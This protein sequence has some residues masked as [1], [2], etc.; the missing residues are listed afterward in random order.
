M[1]DSHV[2]VHKLDA[3]VRGK[4][5]VKRQALDKNYRRRGKAASKAG[6]CVGGETVTHRKGFDTSVCTTNKQRSAS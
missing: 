1:T 6:A 4:R 3:L 2:L 5:E